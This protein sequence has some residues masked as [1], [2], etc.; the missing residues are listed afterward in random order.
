M[1][2]QPNIILVQ[3]AL[4]CISIHHLVL[5]I[6]VCTVVRLLVASQTNALFVSVAARSS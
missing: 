1:L 4:L 5:Y 6:V 2:L 3:Y